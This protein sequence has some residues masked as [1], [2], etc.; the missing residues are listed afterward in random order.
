MLVGGEHRN[1]EDGE[2]PGVQALSAPE[3]HGPGIQR[4]EIENKDGKQ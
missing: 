4:S 2:R 3:S 1:A